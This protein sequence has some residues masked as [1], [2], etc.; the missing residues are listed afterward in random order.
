MVL[1]EMNTFKMLNKICEVLDITVV[2][3]IVLASND[4]ELAPIVK[5]R[6]VERLL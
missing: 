5:K 6:L 2:E 4:S 1:R 3:L